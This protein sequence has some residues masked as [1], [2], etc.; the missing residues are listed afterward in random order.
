MVG[1][2]KLGIMQPYIF[3]YIGYFQL[4]KAVDKFVCYDDVTFIKQGWIN[5]NRILM[6]GQPFLFSVPLCDVSSYTLIRDIKINE[7]YY[8][9]WRKKFYKTL[10]QNYKKADYFEPTFDVVKRVFDEP[11]DRISMLASSSIQEVCKYLSINTYIQKTSIYYGNNDLKAEGRI[12]DICKQESASTYINVAGGTSLY[13]RDNFKEN[14]I[15]LQ[16]IK[17]GDIKYQQ[18]KNSFC[19][20]LSI[21]DVMMFNSVER[22]QEMLNN[23]VIM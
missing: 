6:N 7:R 18:F 17:Y 16:F 20:W 11:H 9:I 8:P 22:I 4:I 21:I 13:S 19:P 2:M 3:P 5:R 10:E 12:I 15:V 1:N 23:R 14:G